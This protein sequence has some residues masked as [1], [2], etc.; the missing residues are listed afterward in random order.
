MLAS[1]YDVD[2]F[3]KVQ[4]KAKKHDVVSCQTS[5]R[6]RSGSLSI[7]QRKQHYIEFSTSILMSTDTVSEL[8]HGT[9]RR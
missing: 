2:P 1:L 8:V 6:I 7:V 3:V 5:T 9:P 4:P